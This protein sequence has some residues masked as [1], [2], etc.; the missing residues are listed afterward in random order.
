MCRKKKTDVK[1]A[2][3]ELKLFYKNVGFQ[4]FKASITYEQW[5]LDRFPNLS[6]LICKMEIIMQN[7]QYC[8]EIQTK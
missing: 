8:C 6:F 7:S 4:F 5:H 3:E 2:D 1:R